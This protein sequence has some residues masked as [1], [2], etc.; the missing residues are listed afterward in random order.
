MAFDYAPITATAS[1][2]LAQFGQVCQVRAVTGATH[3]PTT[4]AMSGGTTVDTDVN[5]VI[6]DF[7]ESNT[8][9]GA[10]IQ[11]GDKLAILDGSITVGNELVHDAEAWECVQVWPVK[12]GDTS[13]VW[14]AQ[15][16]K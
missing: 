5:A 8:P 14:R 9:E 11:A 1:R 12:P 13:I 15:L 7:T 4:G 10:L 16:R 2:L 6:V 3:T